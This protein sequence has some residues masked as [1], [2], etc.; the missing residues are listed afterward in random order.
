MIKD[1]SD[2]QR[3][4]IVDARMVG[5]S[6]TKTVQMFASNVMII[7]EKE[8]KTSSAKHKSD[9]KLKLLERTVELQCLIFFL[10]LMNIFSILC[11]QK[12]PVESCTKEY[13]KEELQFE[14]FC[15]YRS[16]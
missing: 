15:F 4:Q 9:R 12:L 3:C 7:F 16:I 6:V 11:P 1:L 5:A 13:S 2:F 14:N 10:C 8:K